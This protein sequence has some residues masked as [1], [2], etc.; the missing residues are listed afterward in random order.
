MHGLPSLAGGSTRVETFPFDFHTTAGE[1]INAFVLHAGD[2]IVYLQVSVL[3]P[4]NGTS[5]TMWLLGPANGVSGFSLQ[6]GDQQQGSSPF[7]TPDYVAALG[8]N[9]GLVLNPTAGDENFYFTYDDG[10]G[11]DPGSTVGTAV[12]AVVIA[13]G[14]ADHA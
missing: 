10:S 11:G 5:P 1:A 14:I 2:Q 3:I 7:F 6:G 13:P 4:W 8:T 9:T 12:L